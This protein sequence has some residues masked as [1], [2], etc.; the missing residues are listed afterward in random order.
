MNCFVGLAWFLCSVHAAGAECPNQ[1]V[2]ETDRFSLILDTASGAKGDIVGITVSLRSALSGF[3]N[4]IGFI[5]CHDPKVAR[6]LPQPSVYQEIIALIGVSSEF[7]SDLYFNDDGVF[8]ISMGAGLCC[9]EK[10]FPSETPMR[11]ATIYYELIGNPGDSTAISI[12][13]FPEVCVFPGLWSEKLHYVSTGN[14][15]GSISIHDGPPTQADPPVIFPQP[16]KIYAVR[17]TEEQ[18]ALRVEMPPVVARPGAKGVPVE[19]YITSAVEYFEIVLPIDF[20]ERYLRLD[21]VENHF[22]AGMSVIDNRNDVAGGGPEEGGVGIYGSSGVWLRRIAAENEEY[23]AATLYFDVL[24]AANGIDSS[25]LQVRRV[26]VS[27][28]PPVQSAYIEAKWDGGGG[29]IYIQSPIPVGDRNGMLFFDGSSPVLRGDANF[30]GA[31]DISDAVA[32]L[33][34]LFSG[35]RNVLCR[36]AADFNLDRAVDVSD[37]IAFLDSLFLGIPDPGGAGPAEVPCN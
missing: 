36:G 9:Y 16:A 33:S 35:G 23:H 8:S 11:I 6:V 17:P 15:D 12:C 32:L 31:L 28:F 26:T 19:I 3:M 13:S 10:A 27:G 29:L 25:M 22:P 20:D 4:G 5:V 34:F 2:I 7:D 1:D 37:A 24:D 30:D 21:R 14:V 18:V